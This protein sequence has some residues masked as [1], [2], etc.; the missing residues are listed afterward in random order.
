METSGVCRPTAGALF[1]INFTNV[2]NGV[3]EDEYFKISHFIQLLYHHFS[4]IVLLFVHQ[5]LAKFHHLP[6]H[7]WRYI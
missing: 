6:E 4:R 7:E 3:T 1:E 2:S 5:R